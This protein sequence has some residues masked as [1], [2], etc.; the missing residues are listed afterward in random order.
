MRQC[1]V[2]NCSNRYLAKGYC[3]KHYSA[4]LRAGTINKDTRY[5]TGQVVILYESHAEIKLTPSLSTIIDL[6]DVTKVTKYNWHYSCG[7]ACNNTIG[8]LHR[9]LISTPEELDTDHIDHDKLNNRKSNLRICTR[10]EN[11][12]NAI[13]RPMRGI[14]KLSSGHWNVR[15]QYNKKSHCVGT[16]T[17]LQAAQ[18]ARDTKMKQLF[19]VFS[20]V[21]P[22]N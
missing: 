16:F 1:T 4:A 17:T 22:I 12:A 9:Y 6:N 5:D 7:Y 18:S 21:S 10:S 20:P 8:K 3:S 15:V 19:N 11:Q 13:M 2:D 14:R